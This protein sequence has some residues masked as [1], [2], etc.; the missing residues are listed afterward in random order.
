MMPGDIVGLLGSVITFCGGALL[1][2]DSVLVARHLRTQKGGEALLRGLER[3]GV[4]G[5]LVDDKGSPLVTPTQLQLWL[6]RGPQNRAI[7]GFLLVTSG[8]L[9]EIMSRIALLGSH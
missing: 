3:H 1:S 7:F 4:R 2:I 5:I 9:L 8:F 6:L